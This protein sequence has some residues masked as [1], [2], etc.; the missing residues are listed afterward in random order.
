MIVASKVR[1]SVA[2]KVCAMPL[3][4]SGRRFKKPI[5]ISFVDLIAHLFD[6]NIYRIYNEGLW[7]GSVDLSIMGERVSLSCMKKLGLGEFEGAFYSRMC[8]LQGKVWFVHS[9]P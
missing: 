8:A 3:D 6:S 1:P 2:V 7:V 4:R 9:R 5:R